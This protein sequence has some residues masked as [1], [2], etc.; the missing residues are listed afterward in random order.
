MKRKRFI[1]LLMGQF[2]LSLKEAREESEMMQCVQAQREIINRAAK[3]DGVRFRI[4]N[5]DGYS[6]RWELYMEFRAKGEAAVALYTD[7]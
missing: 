3:M 2:G 7:E 6:G 4:K 1:K 5:F